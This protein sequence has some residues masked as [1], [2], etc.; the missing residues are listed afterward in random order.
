[1]QSSFV[2]AAC[3]VV[4]GSILCILSVPAFAWGD[5]GH[6]VIGL[7]ADHYLQP[8]VRQK[9]E[10]MLAGDTSNLAASTSISDEAT[11]ADKFRDSDRNTTKVRYNLTQQWHFVDIEIDGPDYDGA[12]FSHP[13]PSPKA[14]AGPA[15]ACVVDRI[16][17]FS[18]ELKNAS[19]APDERR[20]A[21]Q[22]L[23][24]LVGDAH[25]PLHTID[26]H[27]KGGNDKK[28]K[29][30]SEAT[31][32]LH[33]YWDVVFVARLGG[34]PTQIADSVIKTVKAS[35]VKAWSKGTAKSWALQSSQIARSHG[36]GT[37]PEPDGNG[38][39]MLPTSYVTAAT[40]LSARQL[41][42]AGVRLAKVLN[43]ALQ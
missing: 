38:T 15:N 8:G 19:T 39:Y 12:C 25:Q 42:R 20:L 23:L 31:G 35:D 10:A 43:D 13:A 32:T 26:E 40:K 1:M 41:A 34:T 6:R 17:A 2:R 16:N 9:V 14:S 18:A 28:A 33:H 4:T 37:L 7:I 30:D 5:A 27:D 22:F 21:L 29:S 3:A 36:Y 24:H 11:W